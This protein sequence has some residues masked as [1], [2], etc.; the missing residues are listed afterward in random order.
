[1]EIMFRSKYMKQAPWY[2]FGKTVAIALTILF[3]LSDTKIRSSTSPMVSCRQDKN[4]L[5]TA[6]FSEFATCSPQKSLGDTGHYNLQIQNACDPQDIWDTGV[7]LAKVTPTVKLAS[8]N[9]C[10]MLVN[11][12]E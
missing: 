10:V 12:D 3:F 5:H 1:M 7:V 2:A 9:K 4:Q 6:S 8:A 11:G